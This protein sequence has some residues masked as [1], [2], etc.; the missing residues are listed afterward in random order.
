MGL[1]DGWDIFGVD[2]GD[3]GE[4]LPFGSL[5]LDQNS[6]DTMRVVA[7]QQSSLCS[8]IRIQKVIQF[9]LDTQRIQQRYP[10]DGPGVVH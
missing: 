3:F 8:E 9:V 6:Q 10:E 1:L 7:L 5:C 4:V 2:A